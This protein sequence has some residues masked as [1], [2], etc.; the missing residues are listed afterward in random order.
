MA[1]VPK[2][3]AAQFPASECLA[4]YPVRVDVWLPR[5]KRELVH[6][7]DRD[8]VANVKNARSFVARQAVH[9]LWTV[10]LT[11]SHRSV[12]DR[13][14]PCVA[15]LKFQ[16]VAEAAL[17]R[18]CE[19]IIGA[20]PNVTFVVDGTKAIAAWI[21]LVQRADAISVHRVEG[22]RFGAQVYSAAREQPHAPASEI[23]SRSQKIGGQ[24]MFQAQSPCLHVEIPTPLPL[25]GPWMV[26]LLA[27]TAG[28]DKSGI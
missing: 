16:P 15:P 5:P 28:D 1:R 14:R 26:G 20:R 9:I 24:F 27:N 23:L 7:V 4:H 19:S 13:V 11:A 17:Q 12:I 8:V 6:G 25:Q 10:G 22:D 18:E 21:V 2:A 3:N